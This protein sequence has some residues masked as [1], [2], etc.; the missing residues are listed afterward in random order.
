MVVKNKMY[1]S[2]QNKNNLEYLGRVK[3]NLKKS[4]DQN[5]IKQEQ[6]MLPKSVSTNSALSIKVSLG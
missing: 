6:V 4:V 3:G 2:V 1:G 5:K